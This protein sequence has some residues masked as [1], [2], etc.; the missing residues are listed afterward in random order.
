MSS[1]QVLRAVVDERLYAAAEDIFQA[2]RR[3]IE[4]YEEEL[5]HSK[6]EI[7]RQQRLL[8]SLLASRVKPET[9]AGESLKGSKL[10]LLLLGGGVGG[11]RSSDVKEPT[12]IIG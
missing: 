4:G 10:L 7:G 11:T 6:R 9:P 1:I 3:T 5:Q 12:R 8:Q 2:L